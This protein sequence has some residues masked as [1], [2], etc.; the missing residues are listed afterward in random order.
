[1]DFFSDQLA[2]NLAASA[3]T[4]ARPSAEACL[5]S[6]FAELTRLG[7]S[8]SADVPVIGMRPN[9][10][11]PFLNVTHDDF[12]GFDIAGLNAYGEPNQKYVYDDAT[13]TLQRDGLAPFA[14]AALDVKELPATGVLLDVGSQLDAVGLAFASKGW[15]VL[16]VEP[17]AWYVA[18]QNATRCLNPSLGARFTSVEAA[19]A[20]PDERGPCQ[21]VTSRADLGG[22][23][24]RCASNVSSALV[25]NAMDKEKP[26]CGSGNLG[27]YFHHRLLC[28]PVTPRTLDD[29]LD[30]LRPASVDAVRVGAGTSVCDVFAGGHSLWRKWRPAAIVVDTHGIGADKEGCVAELAR[31]ATANGY[32]SDVV[33]ATADAAAASPTWRHS[34]LVMTTDR[35]EAREIVR[36]PR[37]CWRSEIC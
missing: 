11:T 30:E 7:G 23:D 8:G 25:R 26:A 2:S 13:S 35:R 31:A 24:L 37:F 27:Y 19:V 28:Q 14:P 6:A 16:S 34:H 33:A 10:W 15:S 5:A 22:G 21:I 12:T 1:M 32:K 29:L 9:Q 17:S 4:P 36:E 3:K 18:A 20:G